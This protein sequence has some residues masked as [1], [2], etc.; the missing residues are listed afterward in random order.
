MTNQQSLNKAILTWGNLGYF[1]LWLRDQMYSRE[2][3]NNG[4]LYAVEKN[5]IVAIKYLVEKVADIHY[6]R[7]EALFNVIK[8]GINLKNWEIF[9]TLLK[10]DADPNARDGQA[11][12]DLINQYNGPDDYKI[13]GGI[14]QLLRYGYKTSI[15]DNAALVLAAKRTFGI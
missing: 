2:V 9:I 7:D 11:M 3:L 10:S 12:I 14:V 4:L 8:S 1:E 6:N 15:N 13:Y 5:K